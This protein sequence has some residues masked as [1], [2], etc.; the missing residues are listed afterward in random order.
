M[1]KTISPGNDTGQKLSAKWQ[2]TK[3]HAQ[4][5]S[6]KREFEHALR[7]EKPISL[8]RLPLCNNLVQD[9]YLPSIPTLSIHSDRIILS[10]QRPVQRKRSHK[11][12][13]SES[14]LTRGKFNGWMSATTKSKVRKMLDNWMSGVNYYRLYRKRK[15]DK[16]PAYMTFVTLTLSDV[17]SH[18]D[19]ELKRKLL[20]PFIQHLKRQHGVRFYFWRAEAQRNGNI[21]FHLIVDKYIYSG[22]LQYHW[23]RFQKELGYMDKYMDEHHSFDAPSTDIRKCP[24]DQKLINY[25]MKYVGKN[26]KKITGFRVK[27]GKREKVRVYVSESTDEDGRKSFYRVRMLSGR[28]WGC[29]DE[30]RDLVSHKVVLSQEWY[31]LLESATGAKKFNQWKSDHCIMWF[32][33]VEQ[34]LKEMNAAVYYDYFTHCL[35]EFDRLYFNTGTTGNGCQLLEESLRYVRSKSPPELRKSITFEQLAFNYQLN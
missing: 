19:N 15:Y 26:P 2:P 3:Q 4:S 28:I 32:G 9:D 16:S 34:V 7:N 10:W 30:L 20:M 11:Q 23:N 12:L 18:G 13:Q 5:L 31:E 35:Q 17:Q 33:D 6:A 25:V 29:S 27:D 8:V 24:K 21:H 22:D 1:E 14:N